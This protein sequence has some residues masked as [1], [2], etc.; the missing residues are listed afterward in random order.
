P[1]YDVD[2]QDR[3]SRTAI[4]QSHNLSYTGGT[5]KTNYGLFLGYNKENGIIKT[6]YMQRANV[7]GVI[8]SEINDWIKVGGT[9]NYANNHE[10]RADERVGA[11]NV[12]RMMIEMIPI[13]PYK[14]PDG[15]YGRRG[16][17]PDMESGDNPQAQLHENNRQY[18]Y[19]TFNGN[20]Y[21]TLTPLENLEFTSRF[22]V[23]IRN[24]HNPYF[25]ST[26]SNLEGLGRNY[27]EIWSNESRF[28]QWTNHLN[29]DWQIN[30]KHSLYT[31]VGTE[32]QRSDYL[33]WYSAT[34]D[35]PDDYYKWY[36]L[37]TGSTPEA[38]ESGSNIWQMA[39]YFARFNYN[40]D[41]RYLLTLTGRVDGSSRFGTDNKYAFFPSAAL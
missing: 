40:F 8:D 1:L 37:N 25:N 2:W 38:P 26:L 4:S 28:W 33:E 32:F 15:T 16:D 18:R 23:N 9:I 19:N 34:R 36:D 7:R 10:R 39:S 17:Y 24:Q 3:V 35:M 6:T 30:D 5:E 27:A 11:N 14:Y 29:Y 21:A 22:G 20:T 41:E 31:T 12:P 13:V